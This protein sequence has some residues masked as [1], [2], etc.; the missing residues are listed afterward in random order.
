MR[1]KAKYFRE[2][3]ITP[4][5]DSSRYCVVK[6]DKLFSEDLR[7]ELVIAFAI[8][9]ADQ[10]ADVDWHPKS[11]DMVQ[12]LVHP[13][14]YPFIYGNYTSQMLPIVTNDLCQGK[15]PL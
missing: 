14:M 2:T 10:A 15:H 7:A 8:L 11:N 12:D 4:T 6:S 9:R 13:S 1:N 5:L 3:G